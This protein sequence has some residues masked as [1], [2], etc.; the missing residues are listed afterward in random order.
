MGGSKLLKKEEEIMEYV[1]RYNH[2]FYA[3][4]KTVENNVAGRDFCLSSVPTVVID[5]MNAQLT[6]LIDISEV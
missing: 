6:A 4:V 3:N 2:E 5:E 1:Q